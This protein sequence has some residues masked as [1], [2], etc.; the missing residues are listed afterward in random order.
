MMMLGL[1]T[2]EG[3]QSSASGLVEMGYSTFFGM[4]L[5]YGKGTDGCR[6]RFETKQCRRK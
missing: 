1:I 3:W 2:A 5:R 6:R 4:F